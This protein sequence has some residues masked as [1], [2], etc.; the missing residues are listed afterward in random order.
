MEQGLTL[1]RRA[2]TLVIVGMPAT[3]AK[4]QIGAVD[5]ADNSQHILGSKMGSTRLHVDVPKLVELYQ[6]GRLK[7]DELI[8]ARYPLEE[9][10]PSLSVLCGY[11]P[12]M[13]PRAGGRSPHITPTFRPW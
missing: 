3:G 11:A 5:L 13:G 2:G 6:Q 9:I 12:E 1:L 4:L 7:L 8:T 10:L